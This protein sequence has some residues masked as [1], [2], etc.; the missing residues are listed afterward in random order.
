MRQTM[1]TVAYLI[2][3]AAGLAAAVYVPVS[4]GLEAGATVREK[5][6]GVLFF[7]LVM[8]VVYYAIWRIFIV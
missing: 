7:L 4:L 2:A 6:L 5:I 3:V 1:Q 8:A